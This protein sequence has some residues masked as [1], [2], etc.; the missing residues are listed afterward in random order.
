MKSILISHTFVLYQGSFVRSKS[1]DGQHHSILVSK[2]VAKLPEK[3]LVS[4]TLLRTVGRRA[5]TKSLV[6]GALRPTVGNSVEVTRPFSGLFI[7]E[8]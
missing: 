1:Y 8:R 2:L 5:P 7:Y 6:P 3:G 4:P